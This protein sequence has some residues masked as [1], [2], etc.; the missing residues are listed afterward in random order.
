M[1][2]NRLA[3]TFGRLEHD[4]LELAPGLNV[5]E[6]PGEA[7]KSAWTAFL[8][9]MLYGPGPRDLGSPFGKRGSRRTL[10]GVMEVT[11][12]RG[13][14][15]IFRST[16]QTNAPRGSF[17]AVYTGTTRPVDWLSAAGCG[18]ALLGVS[19][20]VFERSAYIRQADIA[21]EP[22]KTPERRVT[23]LITTG[24]EN[25]SFSAAAERLRGQLSARRSNQ[26]G[27]IPQLEEEIHNVRAAL[28]NLDAL[29]Q[30]ASQDQLELEKLQADI[31]EADSLLARH[32]AA[33][34]LD[35]LR[36]VESARLDVASAHDKVKALE[37]DARSLPTRPELEKLQGRIDA[38]SSI[39]WTVEEASGRLDAAS[40]ALRT[41]TEAVEAH[42][43]AGMTPD[44]AAEAPVDAGPK[45]RLPRW[46]IPVA[47]LA[48]LLLG[49]SVAFFSHL[50]A[51][52]AGSG[53]GLFGVILLAGSTRTRKR[54]H[55]WIDERARLL[56][57]RN[58]AAE[59]YAPLYEAAERARVSY[60]NALSSWEGASLSAK[61]SRE[62]VLS[63]LRAFRPMVRNLDEACQA[64]D[65]AFEIRGELDLAIHREAELRSRWEALRDAAPPIPNEPA[66]RPELSRE[67]L[68][69]RRAES[70]EADTA[71]RGH[72]HAILN[73]MQTLG[74]PQE[75]ALR[76]YALEER[77]AQL[78]REY[79]A[80]AL[81]A[82]ALFTAGSTFQNQFSPALGEHAASIFTTL[83]GG[84]YN[85]LA[86][87][88]ALPLP[89]RED[90]P[91][92]NPGTAD[93]VYLAV[94]LALCDMLLPEENAVPLLLDGALVN[95][96]DQR[97][98]AALDYFLELA[99]R[100]QILLFT[101]QRREGDYLNWAYPDRFHYIKL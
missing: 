64:L 36:D 77:R 94:R 46:L 43:C 63:Q 37:A 27:L 68:R 6:V 44:E 48:G 4:T 86:P 38:L 78:L 82:E 85:R 79:D 69:L 31:L 71:A 13:D 50:W 35:I 72:L 100:R 16:A 92:L 83:T 51:V 90:G 7:D 95:F 87:V 24:E 61:A 39:N 76:L 97:M 9:V 89:L 3:A 30:A 65:Q 20:D 49:G 25:A 91:R 45:P 84:Q 19:R 80:A 42:R 15:T 22:E 17:S 58:E 67:Q 70:L 98:A 73:R 88:R 59:E 40:R 33:D 101:C 29:S 18:E 28:L 26:S 93:Q 57:E 96:D 1:Q 21:A 55:A 12:P 32:N 66:Q 74:D 99:A 62:A 8:R 52:A 34:Q 75:L 23:S 14:V 81:A 60:Q 10:E 47:I 53:L 41:A 11:T 54:Q 5:I 2:I 56:R